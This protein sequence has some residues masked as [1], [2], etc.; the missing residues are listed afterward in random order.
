MSAWPWLFLRVIHLF[1]EVPVSIRD[2]L[3]LQLHFLAQGSVLD[4]EIVRNQLEVL[5]CLIR[6]Q[7]FVHDVDIRGNR[8]VRGAV[9]G[10]D[11]RDGILVPVAQND[12]FEYPRR[13][14]Q[15][16]L[17]RLRR[18]LLTAARDDDVLLAVG[19]A[20]EAVRVQLADVARVEPAVLKCGR[21]LLG[22]VPVAFHDAWATD[23][24]LAV[25]RD[26]NLDSLD[27]AAHRAQFVVLRRIHGD[28]RGGLGQAVA[29]HDRHPDAVEEKRVFAREYGAD[30][31]AGADSPAKTPAQDGIDQLVRDR[32]LERE[33]RGNGPALQLQR[34]PA[35]RDSASPERHRGARETGGLRDLHGPVDQ[36]LVEP[37]DRE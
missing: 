15:R 9:R 3:P 37:R 2:D 36:L 7:P 35:L 31:E 18:D 21:G 19:D 22:S 34:R 23:Q 12:R 30:R 32:V 6:R 16:V 10:D 28:H 17:D 13:L 8:L 27:G 11:E 25:P 26:P 14:L 33:Q 24:D 4:A 1:D 5:D 20:Q 29:L